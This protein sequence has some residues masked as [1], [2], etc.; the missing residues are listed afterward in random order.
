MFA[1]AGMAQNLRTVK[2]AVM[3]EN[4]EPMSGVVVKAVNSDVEA[5]TDKSGRFEL[6][7]DSYI[8]YIEA[9]FEN[10]ITARAEVDGS[11]IIFAF[12]KS[13]SIDSFWR[14]YL[15]INRN[16][17]SKVITDIFV[18]RYV[19]WNTVDAIAIKV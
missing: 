15:F 13:Y 6:K 9:S 5:I 16:M 18:C 7:V 10:Y 4:D 3:N 8:K 12:F 1:L 19:K 17:N 2:G 11:Y 14:Y